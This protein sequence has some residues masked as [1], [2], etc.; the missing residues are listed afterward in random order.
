MKGIYPIF[1]MFFLM[2]S[3]CKVSYKKTHLA[4]GAATASGIYLNTKVCLESAYVSNSP[5]TQTT[6]LNASNYL[7]VSTPYGADEPY[8]HYSLNDLMLTPDITNLGVFV[9]WVVIEVY[10]YENGSY[11]Y[12]DGQSAIIHEN[13][14]IYDTGGFQGI[15]FPDLQPGSYYINV[16]HRNHLSIG[17]GSAV[18]LSSTFNASNY[19]IDF[20]NPATLYLDDATLT[21]YTLKDAGN[22]KCLKAGDLNFDLVIDAT[23]EAEIT[24]DITNVVASPPNDIAILGYRDSDLDLDGQSQKYTDGAGTIP[25]PDL[26]LIIN[27]SGSSGSIY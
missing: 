14:T 24:S 22:V 2:V 15:Y 7:P 17:S 8:Y 26:Q 12:R 27:N 5:L 3:S 10:Q 9:D 21:P 6:S 19:D 20:T 1:A 25:A 16:L 4:K 13:G 18:T 23:D 11:F